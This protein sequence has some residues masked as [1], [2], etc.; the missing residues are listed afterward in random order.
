MRHPR[1]TRRTAG[2]LAGAVALAVA[3]AACTVPAPAPID[4]PAQT[5]GDLPD[6]TVKQLQDAATHAMAAAGASGAV[7]GVWAPWSGSW[8]T[9]LGT[10][11][12]GGKDSV[13]ADLRFK[14]GQIT[15]AMTC[16]VLYALADKGT[17]SLDDPITDYVSGVADLTSI[18]LG[19]LC[20]S[21][22]GIG[23]YSGQLLSSWLSNPMR[24]WNP[25]ELASFG[26]G[27]ARTIEPGTSYV[28]SDAGYLLL[29]LALERASG[30]TASQ[31]LD[32]YIDQPLGLRATQL[33]SPGS[34]PSKSEMLQGYL[35]Q[36]D[37]AGTM[38]CATP[39]DVTAVST[40]TGYTDSGVVSDIGDLGRYAQALA[41]GALPGQT[42]RFSAP[43]PVYAGAPSW[44]TTAGGAIQA[45]SLI[46]QSGGV[47]GYATAAFADPTTG[48]TVAVVLNNSGAGAGLAVY[49]AWELAALASKAA[50]ASG[51]TMPEAGLPWTAQQYHDAIT[52]AAICPLP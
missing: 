40:T 33:P 6:D 31:L 28:D 17:V 4:L 34:E 18:T 16:D 7:V 25:R 8:V 51:E 47:P 38:N 48:L 41:T 2:A 27:E 10:E 26:L 14:V 46:G 15:R 45:G 32:Q 52:A 12:P 11:T 44:Y 24:T 30:K 1:H 35:S 20:A 43:L 21:T 23:S 37:A 49:L 13:S 42:D 36:R 19:E 29:G 39:L 50:A 5:Q 9:G 22:S 3:L